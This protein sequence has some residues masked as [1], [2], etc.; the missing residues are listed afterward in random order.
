MFLNEEYPPNGVTIPL[1]VQNAHSDASPP[2]PETVVFSSKS[3]GRMRIVQQNRNTQSRLLAW[4]P[5]FGFPTLAP[6]EGTPIAKK[7]LAEIGNVRIFLV[8]EFSGIV[9]AG[10]TMGSPNEKQKNLPFAGVLWGDR[11]GGYWS[12]EDE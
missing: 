7:K 12:G 4:T 9:W 5:S 2:I 6:F 10:F 3:S 11:A 8:R 1:Q